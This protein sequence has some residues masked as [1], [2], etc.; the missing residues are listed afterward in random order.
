MVAEFF[1]GLFGGAS[2]LASQYLGYKYAKKLQNH[3][4]ELNTKA[5]QN[6]YTNH[7]MSLEKADYNPLLNV[8]GSSAQGFT[9]G[10]SAPETD[11]GAG[12]QSGL[13]S[14]IAIKTAKANIDKTKSETDINKYGKNGAILKNLLN[15][16]KDKEISNNPIVKK[17]LKG[18]IVSA[19]QDS[20]S[21][22][23]G[24]LANSGVQWYKNWFAQKH[25]NTYKML[26]NLKHRDFQG[27]RDAFRAINYRG[28]YSPSSAII[29]QKKNPYLD[30]QIYESKG[31]KF[32]Y[33]KDIDKYDDWETKHRKYKEYDRPPKGVF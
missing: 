6:Y 27:A 28:H 4:Y 29:I 32:Q 22:V 17:V 11:I 5:L 12:I 20:P 2:A 9:A 33:I 30:N 14:A 1:G 26:H 19:L 23:A 8:P 25:P 10:A 15:L 21:A 31:H 3:Q 13:N 18:E 16:G 24:Q 7:R